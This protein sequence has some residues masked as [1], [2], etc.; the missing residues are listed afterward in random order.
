MATV[1]SFDLCRVILLAIGMAP[2]FFGATASS[3]GLEAPAETRVVIVNGELLDERGLALVDELN[4]GEPVANGIYWLDFD[5]RVWGYVGSDDQYP[6]PDC[7][8][9]GDEAPPEEDDCESKYRFVEDRMCYCHGI[10]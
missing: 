6:L 4:C 7:S 9:G 1:R 3:Q 10:C 5:N 8:G 2:L